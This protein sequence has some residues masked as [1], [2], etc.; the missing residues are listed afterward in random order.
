LAEDERVEDAGLD[1]EDTSETA[2]AVMSPI[3]A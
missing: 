3:A 2:D 1:Y